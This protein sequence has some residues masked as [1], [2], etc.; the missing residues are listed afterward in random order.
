MSLR[1]LS[2]TSGLLI[3]SVFFLGISGAS[4]HAER[5]PFP[6]KTYTDQ[7]LPVEAPPAQAR[8]IGPIPAGTLTLEDVLRTH[9]PKKPKTVT[10]SPAATRLMM[11]QGMSA[12]FQRFGVPEVVPANMAPTAPSTSFAD[13]PVEREETTKTASVSIPLSEANPSGPEKEGEPKNLLIPPAEKAS[14]EQKKEDT[15]TPLKKTS[16]E[17]RAFSEVQKWEKSCGEAGYP[18]SF[19]G[20]ISG[21]TRT[22]SAN[23]SLHDVWVANTCAP[24]DSPAESPDDRL[25]QPVAPIDGACGTANGVAVEKAPSSDLCR[26]GTASEIQGSG[27]WTW[28]CLPSGTEGKS[29]SCTAPILKKAP[30]SEEG[31]IDALPPPPAPIP[32]LEERKDVLPEKEFRP[33]AKASASLASVPGP[34]KNNGANLCGEASETMAY[35]APEKNLCRSGSSSEVRGNGPWMWTCTNNEGQKSSCETL[36]LRGSD[37]T[38]PVEGATDSFAPETAKTEPPLPPYA[39]GSA[40]GQPARQAPKK[41]LCLRGAPSAVKG[42]NPSRWSCGKGKNKVSCATVQIIDGVCGTSDGAEFKTAPHKNLCKKGVAGEVAGNG[43]WN[44]TCEGI[45]GGSSASCAAALVQDMTAS[46]TTGKD[47]DDE[48]FTSQEQKSLIDPPKPPVEDQAPDAATEASIPVPEKEAKT[49]SLDPTLSTILFPNGSK[50]IEGRML[51]SLDKLA[52]VLKENPDVRISL[53]AYA[54]NA[55]GQVTRVTRRLSLDR[56]LVVRGYLEAKGIAESRVD[57]RAEGKSAPTGY[58][59]RVDV[60]IY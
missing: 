33:A 34:R 7:A 48:T 13:M 18:A 12:I 36:S 1:Y 30:A 15:E 17:E 16:P 31:P 38:A 21:E 29:E 27:P 35:E 42:S 53:T 11:T 46:I 52:A 44:W 5:D 56:A 28:T 8:K 45:G 39:C 10:T 26:T 54:D 50:N 51:L 59:D 22:D 4:A 20:K 55:A 2:N 49:L 37:N 19:I 6:V 57:I 43:P 24:P 25:T 58:P 14:S 41:D 9:A 23:G 40:D 60:K 3:V 47:L 32:S